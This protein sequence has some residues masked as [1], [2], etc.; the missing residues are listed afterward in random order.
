MDDLF[1]LLREHGLTSEGSLSRDLSQ[2]GKDHLRVLLTELAAYQA[3]PQVMRQGQFIFFP[4]GGRLG[5]GSAERAVRGL[6]LTADHI[7]LPNDLT[8]QAK[9]LL[10]RLEQSG[11]PDD[12]KR[13]FNCALHPYLFQYLRLQPLFREGLASLAPRPPTPQSLVH[14]MANGLKK[15]FLQ[16]AEHGT[17]S[18]G[19][20]WMVLRIGPNYW[21]A[22]DDIR[23]GETHLIPAG[24]LVSTDDLIKGEGGFRPQG[25]GVECLDPD[26]LLSGTHPLTQA[27]EEFISAE[28]FRVQMLVEASS[29]LNASLVTDIDTDWD[30][31]GLLAG[32]TETAEPLDHAGE[33]A[34]SLGESLPFVETISVENLVKLRV[35]RALEFDAFRAVLL[36]A[37]RELAGEADPERRYHAAHR[38]VIEEIQPRFAEYNAKMTALAWKRGLAAFFAAGAAASLAIMFALLGSETGAATSAVGGAGPYIKRALDAHWKLGAAQGDPMFFLWKLKHAAKQRKTNPFSR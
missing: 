34:E 16:W 30:I 32:R 5:L 36:Q 27:L 20:P 12:V 9:D 2:L 22:F 14:P 17:T 18:D 15:E 38:A 37:S 25:P 19:K 29:K 33:L 7:V 28:L 10:T 13:Q 3:P 6:L 35:D 21:S 23:A 8:S 24:P 4:A 11:K 1:E 26:E 31:L